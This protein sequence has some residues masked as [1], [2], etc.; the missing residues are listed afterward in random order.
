MVHQHDL[1]AHEVGT[2]HLL[3]MSE[4]HGPVHGSFEHKRCGQAALPQAAHEGDCFPMALRRVVD[5][6]PRCVARLPLIRQLFL[7]D[8][9]LRLID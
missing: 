8:D 9:F 6:S 5:W 4:K 3:H 1:G 2:R 7:F